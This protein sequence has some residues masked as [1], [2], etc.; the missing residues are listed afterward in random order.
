[1]SLSV[2]LSGPAASGIAGSGTVLVYG[3]AGVQ[4]E[5]FVRAI[6]AAGVRVRVLL[7][8][9]TANPFGESVDV[10][11]GDMAYPERLRL[12]NLGVDKVVLTLP[13]RAS[14]AVQVQYGRS[15][16]DAAKAAGVKLLVFNASCP[17]P[18]GPGVPQNIEARREVEAYLAASGL[19]AIV[20]RPTLYFDNIAEPW[21][22]A[23]IM[24]QGLFVQ[25]L[26]AEFLASRLSCRD[27]AAYVVE[28]LQRPHL[29][30]RAFDIGG[31]E[32]MSCAEM[33]S[34]LSASAGRTIRFHQLPLP[35]FGASLTGVFGSEVARGI[36]A[37][38]AWCQEQASSPLVPDMTPALQ[39]FS[40]RPTAF[41]DWAAAQ[42]WNRLASM[43]EVA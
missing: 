21:S 27:L 6:L 11:R 8:N 14:S 20:L 18:A 37:Y 19:N 22:A 39:A 17:V 33:A 35:E 38:Y 29:A 10:V 41:G 43:H 26:P 24:A 28:A 16:I 36:V 34:R 12:A 2:D 40:S 32:I 1:M 30:G 25:P 31:T 42:N 3:A 7:R 23:L 4:G 9:G 5:A 13:L 15:A